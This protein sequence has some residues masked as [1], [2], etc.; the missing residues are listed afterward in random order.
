[1]SENR[2]RRERY[3]KSILDFVLEDARQLKASLGYT[4]RRK[5]DEYLTAV[6]E[7][8]GRIERAKDFAAVLPDYSKP[9]GIPQDNQQHIRLMYDLLGAGLS[10]R[11]HSDRHVHDGA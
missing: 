3:K 7:L 5:L 6:R 4:D 2:A 10:N 1:M 8:E 9:S 11:H